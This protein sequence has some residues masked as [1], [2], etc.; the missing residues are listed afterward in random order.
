MSITNSLGSCP[1]CIFLIWTEAARYSATPL[2]SESPG[3]KRR[4]GVPCRLS[5][6]QGLGVS[7]PSWLDFGFVN[8]ENS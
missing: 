3:E 1:Q 4:R 6:K 5:P 2:R 7:V 8:G